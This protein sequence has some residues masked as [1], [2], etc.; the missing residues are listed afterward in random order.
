MEELGEEA[1]RNSSRKA[2]MNVLTRRI[3]DLVLPF[4]LKIGDK[5]AEKAYAYRVDWGGVTDSPSAGAATTSR[6]PGHRSEWRLA[7]VRSILGDSK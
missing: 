1:R 6:H 5:N 2:P 7:G 4:F 3:P